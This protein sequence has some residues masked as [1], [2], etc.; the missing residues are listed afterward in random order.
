MF[1]FYVLSFFK[2]GD[3]IQ[4]GKLFKGGHYSRKYGILYFDFSRY[5]LTT[6]QLTQTF[7][8]CWESNH[9]LTYFYEIKRNKFEKTSHFQAASVSKSEAKIKVLFFKHYYNRNFFHF[10]QKHQLSRYIADKAVLSRIIY[11]HR[12]YFL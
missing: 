1:P 2:K 10:K 9:T 4:G 11:I 7:Q 6:Y 12:R 5:V 3:T 8:V